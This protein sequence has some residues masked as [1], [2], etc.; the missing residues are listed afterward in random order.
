MRDFYKITNHT[1]RSEI[2]FRIDVLKI[3]STN[4]LFSPFY[5]ITCAWN[6]IYIEMRASLM[7]YFHSFK[8]HE[9]HNFKTYFKLKKSNYQINSIEF[10]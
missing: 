4:T 9:F 7:M 10:M 8:S 5:S 1:K 3:N 2:C 6:F